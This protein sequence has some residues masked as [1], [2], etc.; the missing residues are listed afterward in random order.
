MVEEFLAI[1]ARPNKFRGHLQKVF[2]LITLVTTGWRK[3]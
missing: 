1:D 3:E 2:T